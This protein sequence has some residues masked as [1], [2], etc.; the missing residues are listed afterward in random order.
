M[1]IIA[2][3]SAVA[4]DFLFTT[5]GTSGK[6]PKT[7][8]VGK[9]DTSFLRF[10]GNGADGAL[11]LT[12]GTTTTSLGSASVFIKNYSSISITGTAVQAFSSPNSNGSRIFLKSQGDV[13]LTSSATPHL[14][15]S[16]MGA[17][18]G[19][20]SY[21]GNYYT[22]SAGGNGNYALFA[23]VANGA[24]GGTMTFT[25]NSAVFDIMAQ[26]YPFMIPGSGGGD[27]GGG[28]N[29]GGSFV[30]GHGN[31]GGGALCI[32]CGGSLN[33]TI[34]SGISVAGLNGTNATATG[35]TTA[36]AG[37][38]GGGAGS[39]ICYY[40]ALTA[41]TGSVTI[42]GGTGGTGQYTNGNAEASGGGGGGNNT[43][44]NPTSNQST[45]G[46]QSGATGASSFALF[47]QN[48]EFC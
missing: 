44:G 15:A 39:F 32:E 42:T 1:S 31:R 20:S 38:G 28:T 25:P 46:T 7:N 30:A 24:T 23:A 41:N 35:S 48:T 8:S 36:A 34:T 40:N 17:D 21:A 26:K 47:A 6:V 43:T 11:A 4:N 22:V 45:G 14:D 33:F 5:D 16:G 9:I 10:G 2:G 37:G 13:T 3:N 29:G 19:T 12:S 18:R 27:G